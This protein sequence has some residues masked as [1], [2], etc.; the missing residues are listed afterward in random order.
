MDPELRKRLNS[1]W[2]GTISLWLG[3]NARE[4][5]RLSEWCV[6]SDRNNFELL[7]VWL[8]GLKAKHPNIYKGIQSNEKSAHQLALDVLSKVEGQSSQHQVLPILM[9][10]HASHVT[11]KFDEIDPQVRRYFEGF[12]TPTHE[13]LPAALR[14]IEKTID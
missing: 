11:G 10:I 4:A 6:M 3:L 12:H 2:V 13:L 7:T 8:L 1:T 9:K 14:H 5:Q